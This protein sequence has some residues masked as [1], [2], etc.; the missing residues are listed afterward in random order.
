MFASVSMPMSACVCVCVHTVAQGHQQERVAVLQDCIIQNRR[1]YLAKSRDTRRACT[2]HDLGQLE[3]TSDIYQSGNVTQLMTPSY[4]GNAKWPKTPWYALRYCSIKC[5]SSVL[6]N[7][8]HNGVS[9]LWLQETI[10][11]DV[12][13][14]LSLRNCFRIT[15]TS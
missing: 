14:E 5:Q 9:C 13:K 4:V 10:V 2:G 6:S 3:N 15:V 12:Y 8:H 7:G 11:W 1:R